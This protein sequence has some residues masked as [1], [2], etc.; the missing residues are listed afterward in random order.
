MLA[1][2]GR[3]AQR[4]TGGP[5]RVGIR[6]AG[7]ALPLALQ[8]QVESELLLEIGIGLTAAQIGQQAAQPERPPHRVPHVVVVDAIIVG[9]NISASMTMPQG[10]PVETTG[11]AVARLHRKDFRLAPAPAGACILYALSCNVSDAD[12][13]GRLG[14]LAGRRRSAAP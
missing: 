8:V 7:L 9:E 2:Q 4:P 1:D 11:E 10:S 5:P 12:L 13:A 14:P 3:V 6:G